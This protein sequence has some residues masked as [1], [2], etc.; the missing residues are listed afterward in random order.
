V[1]DPWQLISME[2]LIWRGFCVLM[3]WEL[4]NTT[5]NRWASLL[6]IGS[7]T[8]GT[9]VGKDTVRT[10]LILQRARKQDSGNYTCAV[11]DIAE[12]T[13]T[14]HILNGESVCVC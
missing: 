8:P 2:M 11:A 9:L 5:T 14:V 10:V 4:I 1:T 12:A 13:V 6:L 7:V 3:V